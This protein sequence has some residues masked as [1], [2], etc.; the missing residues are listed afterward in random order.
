MSDKLIVTITCDSTMSYPRNPYNP[1]GNHEMAQEIIR[2]VEAGASLAHLH[3]PYTVDEEIKADGKLSDL[4]I[5]GWNELR[6]LILEGC[7][8]IIQY[9]I[10]NGRFAQ[11]KELL[12][13]GPDMISV[14]FNAHD[15]CFHPDPDYPP[16]ELYGIH[17]RDELREYAEVTKQYHVKPEI[18][19]FHMGAIWNAER[20]LGRGFLAKPCWTT[21]FLGW[22][23]GTWTPPTSKALLYMVDHLPEHYNFNVSVMDPPTQWKV[24]TT[25]IMHGG[26]VRVGMEDNPYIDNGQEYAKSNAE[27]VEKIVRIARE[28]GREIASPEEAREIVGFSSG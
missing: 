13:Q 19:A 7:H 18:E 16:V 11:R 24:L 14:C 17:S 20:L 28:M 26:H 12:K 21:L 27:L 1:K 6:E 23:G 25:S 2:S 10:A 3:G 9:G 22:P 4:D 5:E 8:P 15:E